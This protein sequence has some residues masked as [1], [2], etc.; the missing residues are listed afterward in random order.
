MATT[1]K[2]TNTKTVKK[3]TAKPASTNKT[4]AKA[5][6]KTTTKT[7]KPAPKTTVSKK[8][9]TRTASNTKSKNVTVPKNNKKGAHKILFIIIIVVAVLA[10]AT[11]IV[12][13]AI[14]KYCANNGTV[15]IEDGKGE[16]IEAKYTS[17]NG[18]NY[19]IAIPT[20]F[21]DSASETP[22]EGME[23][24]YVPNNDQQSTVITVSKAVDGFTNDQVKEYTEAMATINALGAT[25]LDSKT[26]EA[27]NHTVGVLALEEKSDNSRIY[28]RMAIFSDDDKLV[29]VSFS[30]H[31][32]TCDSWEKVGKTIIDD[33]RFDK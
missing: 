11:G 13:F 24:V 6:T 22:I 27:G 26:Y 30:C 18:S 17:I 33:I 16:K 20:D 2:T 23:A 7:T 12:G 32:D 21:K 4:T 14:C 1:R 3:T 8:P 5:A 15:M 31:N 9:A 10:V 19:H 25:V 28:S 29:I